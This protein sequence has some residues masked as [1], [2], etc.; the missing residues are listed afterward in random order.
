MSPSAGEDP[1]GGLTGARATRIP[2][3]N[4][5]ALLVVAVIALVAVA[6]ASR[7]TAIRNVVFP[8]PSA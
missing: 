7:V 3:M 1:G 5:K 8:A 6:I 4:I 2:T